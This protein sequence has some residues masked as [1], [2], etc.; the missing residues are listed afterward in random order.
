MI[1]FVKKEL[2]KIDSV[3]N[4]DL[5][6]CT[7]SPPDEV[8]E[9]ALEAKEATVKITLHILRCMKEQSLFDKLLQC[10]YMCIWLEHSL[11]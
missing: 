8:D 2:R 7:K 11:H 6:E 1:T 4:P 10:Q 3:L 5:T 9:F